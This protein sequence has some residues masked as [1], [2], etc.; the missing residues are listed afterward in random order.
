MPTPNTLS[1]PLYL[2]PRS[3]LVDLRASPPILVL[4]TFVLSG[5][6]IPSP[7]ASSVLSSP[8]NADHYLSPISLVFLGFISLSRPQGLVHLNMGAGPPLPL[9]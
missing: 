8:S 2:G 3:S 6:L 5:P 7:L 1:H 4:W 9:P